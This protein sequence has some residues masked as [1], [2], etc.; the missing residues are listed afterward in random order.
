DSTRPY[1]VKNIINE[2]V[3]PGSFFE[4]HEGFAKNIVVGFARLNGQSVGLV[5][6]QPKYLAGG[7]DI[8]SS[9]KSARFIR[10]CDSFNI[11]I[12][13]FEDVI[14]LFTFVNHVNMCYLI[15]VD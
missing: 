12:I 4:I 14:G 9:D 1:D 7:L 11:P 13:T 2:V 8:D 10:L 5:C 15:D 3:D 6:N